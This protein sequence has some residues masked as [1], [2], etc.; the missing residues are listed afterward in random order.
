MTNAEI[1]I[2]LLSAIEKGRL[3]DAS[4]YLSDDFV[5]SG[6]VPK[7]IAKEEW[8]GVQGKL[9]LAFPDWS[10]NLRDVSNTGQGCRCKIQITGTHTGDLDLENELDIPMARASYKSI[11]LPEEIC[12]LTFENGRVSAFR[13]LNVTT[14]G[15]IMGIFKQIGV[16]VH[17]HT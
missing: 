6:P 14:D 5:F 9:G 4:R 11:K 8:L 13:V 2:A 16:E 1:C 12:D 17:V 7:P 3:E 15:G 10:F